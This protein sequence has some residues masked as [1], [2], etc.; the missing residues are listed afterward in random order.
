MIV[1]TSIRIDDKTFFTLFHLIFAICE[2]YLAL[3][4]KGLC[5]IYVVYDN[6][7]IIQIILKFVTIK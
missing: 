2:K 1:M 5:Q 4:W 6:L 3:V 7:C